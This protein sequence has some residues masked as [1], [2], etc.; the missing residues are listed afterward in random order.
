MC[1]ITGIL[2]KDG[3]PHPDQQSALMNAIKKMTASL[4][5]RGPDEQRCWINQNKSLALGHARLSIIDLSEAASQPMHYTAFQETEEIERYTITYNGELYNYLEIKSTLLSNGY[6]FKSNSDTEVIL[7]AYDFWRE[8]CLQQ[9]DGMFALAIWDQKTQTIFCARDRFGE[10]PFYYYFDDKQFVFASEM[11]ALWS[12]GIEKKMND[13][14]L[15]NYLALGYLQ[16]ADD[17]KQTFYDDITA[18]SP[19]HFIQ[20]HLPTFS[21]EL[22]EYWKLDKDLIVDV[23]EKDAIE[24]FSYLFEQSV[25]RRLRCDVSIGSSLSGGIDSS[26][27]LATMSKFIPA[28]QLKTY[29]AVFPS[30]EKD[31][32]AYIDVITKKLNIKNYQVV[33]DADGLLSEFKKICYHQEEPFSSS[34]IYAQYK[35][36]ELAKN[37]H[38]RVLLDGQGADETI[39]GYHKYIHWYIQQLLERKKIGRAFKEK[40]I[41]NNNQTPVRW[42]LNNILAT[43]LPA[44]ASIHLEHKEVNKILSNPDLDASFVRSIRGHEWEGIHKPIITKLNDI[45]YFN[46]MSLGLEELLRFADKNS[47]AHGLEV[48]LPFLSHELV[49][50]VF[51]LPAQY[52]IHEGYTK[53][54]LRKSMQ[55]AVP[56]KILWRKDKIGY[57][58]PQAQW[59]KNDKLIDYMHEAKKKLA[60]A[61]ILK[62]STVTQKIIPKGAHEAN[63]FNWRYLCVSEMI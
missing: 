30:F 26:S 8:D 41:F 51:S 58:P 1:G 63:N 54:V 17:K 14:M 57:E 47:M 36:F 18:L 49:S 4:E 25:K 44:H 24:K 3:A 11:K 40:N 29:S 33:P 53:W 10:K 23:N 5:H 42:G 60:N 38:T 45:L 52:K 6:H 39:A 55:S 56:E 27:I 13:K 43:F 48:R 37:N 50:L 20:I 2:L 61:G 34:S 15:A 28:A 21:Y 59:M 32:S 62:K 19:A 9:F 35:V 31:E 22:V 12:I 16:N 46:T 7:A